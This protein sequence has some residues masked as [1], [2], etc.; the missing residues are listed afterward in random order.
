MLS[1]WESIKFSPLLCQTLFDKSIMVGLIARDILLLLKV[2]DVL[3][4]NAI[5]K[6]RNKEIDKFLEVVPVTEAWV[7]IRNIN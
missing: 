4:T 5:K 3:V 1:T 7:L 2:M 6:R